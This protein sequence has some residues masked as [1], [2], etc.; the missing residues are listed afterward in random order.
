M[1]KY[2]DLT[3]DTSLSENAVDANKGLYK[4]SPNWTAG[5]ALWGYTLAVLTVLGGF[6]SHRKGFSA[7]AF[8]GFYKSAT[9]YNYHKRLGNF[10]ELRGGKIRLTVAGWNH[11]SA[12]INGNNPSQVVP[13]SEVE[14]MVN[15]IRT[16]NAEGLAKS[17]DWVQIG[18]G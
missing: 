11:F 12:R 14:N 1:A 6:T 18:Q 16:G 7:T 5:K 3:S 9:A 4:A 13:K 2:T 8:K 17:R 10:E 15:A